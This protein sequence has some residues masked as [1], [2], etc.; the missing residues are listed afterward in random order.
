[1][2]QSFMH[3]RSEPQLTCTETVCPKPQG[4]EVQTD[5]CLTFCAC[6]RTAHERSLR[7]CLQLQMSAGLCAP[8]SS[9]PSC[10]FRRECQDRRRAQPARV[11]A[12]QMS[13]GV[14]RVCAARRLGLPNWWSFLRD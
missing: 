12:A 9:L 5:V 4:C 3:P 11:S 8:G 1:M 14:V 6:C 10:S 7:V 13:A 2:L